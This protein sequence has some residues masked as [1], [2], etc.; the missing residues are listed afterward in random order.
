[1]AK[2]RS[3]KLKIEWSGIAPIE[4]GTCKL[5]YPVVIRIATK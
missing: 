1:M 3:K 4:S 5:T 2:K